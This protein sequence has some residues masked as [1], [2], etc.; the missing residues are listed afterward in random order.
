[1]LPAVRRIALPI[2]AAK[3]RPGVVAF[4]WPA[5]VMFLELVRL[6][7]GCLVFGLEVG[8]LAAGFDMRHAASAAFK[9]VKVGQ[10]VKSRRYPSEPHDLRA[11]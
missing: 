6:H 5:A 8:D 10:V 3:E 11:A 9:G 1:M 4:D 2:G 7:A